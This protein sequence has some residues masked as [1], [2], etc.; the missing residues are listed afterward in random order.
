LRA[1]VSFFIE[2]PMALPLLT[3][4][5]GIIGSPTALVSKIPNPDNVKL[6]IGRWVPRC[7]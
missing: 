3:A 1:V 6:G 4:W 7:C 2:K 5:F